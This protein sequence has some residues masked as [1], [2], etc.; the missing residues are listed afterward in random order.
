[1][2]ISEW[3]RRLGR[4][5]AADGDTSGWPA[6]VWLLYLGFLFMPLAWRQP[7]WAWLAATLVSLPVFLALYLNALA[8]RW[9]P[10]PKTS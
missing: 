6:Y 9:Q 7:G 10:K 1:M 4:S 3:L 8:A 2:S 5:Q